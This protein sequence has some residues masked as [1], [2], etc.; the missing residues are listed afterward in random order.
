MCACSRQAASLSTA[1]LHVLLSEILFAVA[2]TDRAPA[3]R[4]AAAERGDAA[5]DAA[6]AF[7]E[8]D[9]A[10]ARASALTNE[11]VTQLRDLLSVTVR[12]NLPCICG[13]AGDTTLRGAGVPSGKQ[14]KPRTSATL[15]RC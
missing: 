10:I 13:S 11:C 2:A 1:A 5:A 8:H 4:A 15:P 6:A 3:A 14:R 9:A 7:A 12:R